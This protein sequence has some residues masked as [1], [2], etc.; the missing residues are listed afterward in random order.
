[1]ERAIEKELLNRLKVGTFYKN[2]YNLDK[3]EFEDQLNA[4][5]VDDQTQYEIAGEDEELTSEDDSVLGGDLELDEEEQRML[6]MADVD[7]IEDLAEQKIVGKKRKQPK[8]EFETE[9]EDMAAMPKQKI[10]ATHKKLR[11]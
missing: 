7:D 3:K 10:K 9:I 5:E 11:Q 8:V 6:E 4:N 1:M 2:I